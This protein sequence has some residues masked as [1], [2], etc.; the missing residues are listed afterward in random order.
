MKKQTIKTSILF[1][2]LS[3]S[4]MGVACDGT[5]DAARSPQT[6]TTA[7]VALDKTVKA[8]PAIRSAI[9]RAFFNAAKFLEKTE[10]EKV[11]A[12]K[13]AVPMFSDKDVKNL[14]NS[15]EAFLI[16]PEDTSGLLKKATDSAKKSF[17][18]AFAK[19]VAAKAAIAKDAVA[20]AAI[21]KTAAKVAVSEAAA[22]KTGNTGLWSFI[23]NLPSDFKNWAGGHLYDPKFLRGI[24]STVLSYVD[25]NPKKATAIAVVASGLIVWAGVR[26]NQRRA[27]KNYETKKKEFATT[28]TT[29]ILADIRAKNTTNKVTAE[30]A[31][32][33]YD[34]LTGKKTRVIVNKIYSASDEAIQYGLLGRLKK[35]LHAVIK[36]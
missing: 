16:K 35:E 31:S 7:E 29:N 14:N 32:D 1:L 24:P 34:T 13:V 23:C 22:T 17:N 27:I 26:L 3:L 11:K 30:T 19:N 28:I 5:I 36:K 21:A 18:E 25:K 20:K 15:I 4:Q 12:P 9:S 33:S 6:G 8:L 2:L 10:T